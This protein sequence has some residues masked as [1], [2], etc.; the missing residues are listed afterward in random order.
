MRQSAGKV[1]TQT[2]APSRR[3]SMKGHRGQQTKSQLTDKK[4]QDI[5]QNEV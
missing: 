3:Q 5:D 4:K 2:K 1:T